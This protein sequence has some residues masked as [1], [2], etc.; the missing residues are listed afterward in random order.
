MNFT[1]KTLNHF[2]GLLLIILITPA[3]SFAQALRGQV[4][5]KTQP[6]EVLCLAPVCTGWALPPAP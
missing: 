3:L 4:F 6:T 5:D 2:L 1:S